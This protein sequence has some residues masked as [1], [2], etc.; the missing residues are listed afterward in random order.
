M[1]GDS[2]SGNLPT[3]VNPSKKMK[4]HSQEPSFLQHVPIL[5]I[6]T[7]A[8]LIRIIGVNFGLPDLYHADEPIVVNHA[9]A[10]GTGDLNPH[11]F[12]IP[13][14]VSYLLFFIY[15]CYYVIGY[16]IGIFTGVQDFA[17]LFIQ[18]PSSFYLI[19]RIIFGAMTGTATVYVLFRLINK[20]YSAQH[21]LL[22]SF[23]LA[24]SF[25]H[26]RD[27]HYIYTDIP[28]LLILVLCF[29]S[30]FYLVETNK[31]KNTILFGILFGAS[32]AMKYNAVFLFIP[33]LIIYLIKKGIKQTSKLITVIFISALTFFVLNPF[34]LLDF[35]FFVNELLQQSKSEN[36]LGF[37]HHITYSLGEGL[38]WP[39]LLLAAVG[40]AG[41]L[42]LQDWKRWSF[43]LFI[44]VYYFVLCLFSQPYDRYVLPLVPFLIFFAADGLLWLKSR[45]RLRNI[46]FGFILVV[47]SLPS[48]VKSCV[49]D[50]LFMQKDTRLKAKEWIESNIPSNSKIAL[51]TPFYVPKLK[52]SLNQLIERKNEITSTAHDKAQQ[53]RFNL[54]ISE[55]EKNP[56]A[57]YELFFLNQE[58]SQNNFIFSKPSIPYNL[59]SL[60]EAGIEYVVISQVNRN[61]N[62]QF[63]SNL[64]TGGTLLKKFSPYKDEKI[65]WP[66]D[67]LPLTGGPFLWKDLINRHTG[68]Q[69][70]KIY[71]LK[72]I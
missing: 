9:L 29:Y 31:S 3:K 47:I 58:G 19:A 7:L 59:Q 46:L 67:D 12:K 30:M 37:L 70:I 56:K 28:L 16:L 33:F 40:I 42:R 68:G 55:A 14:L 18:S 4:T 43:V 13:P 63:N 69:I 6:L 5:S 52:P 20:F 25:L 24:I 71:K 39:L 2:K 17:A 34:S 48:L 23:F 64:K 36:F 21:A 10:Y 44:G 51:D 60:K 15:G 53:I 26:V 61:L 50:Y 8:F 62:S 1:I 11:F 35:R 54:L 57:R 65:E 38:G 22:A 45:F 66:L 72:N 27:S 41:T 32:V 49:S